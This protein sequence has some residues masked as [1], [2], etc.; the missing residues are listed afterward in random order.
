MVF[1]G[2]GSALLCLCLSSSSLQ[3][4]FKQMLY[5]SIFF[6]STFACTSQFHPMDLIFS[7]SAPL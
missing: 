2:G 1:K 4:V 6:I 7:L 3:T 5:R